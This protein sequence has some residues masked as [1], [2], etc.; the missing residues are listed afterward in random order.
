MAFQRSEAVAAVALEFRPSPACYR[1]AVQPVP[2]RL[3]EA[4]L[5]TGGTDGAAVE[6]RMLIDV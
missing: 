4:Y 3:G 2:L 5:T 6:A 1:D